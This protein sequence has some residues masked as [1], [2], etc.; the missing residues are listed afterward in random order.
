M[1]RYRVCCSLISFIIFFKEAKVKIEKILIHYILWIDR[2]YSMIKRLEELWKMLHYFHIH[3]S[4]E[5]MSIS[6]G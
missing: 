1:V 5:F 2:K 4:N 6:V 3:P